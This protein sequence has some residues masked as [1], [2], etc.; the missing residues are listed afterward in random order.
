MAGKQMEGDNKQ[1]RAAARAAR[2]AGKSAG[3]VGAST[4][5]SQQRSKAEPGMTHQEKLDLKREGKHDVIRENTPEARP[6]SRDADTLDR[7][8]HPRLEE[9]SER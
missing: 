1:R 9:S 3:D 8:R 4:G 6:G 2:E 5:A 7:Q